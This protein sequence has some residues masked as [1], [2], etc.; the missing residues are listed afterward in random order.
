MSTQIAL[1]Y[2][3]AL[4]SVVP[5]D[6]RSLIVEE[7]NRAVSVL[8]DPKIKQVFSYPRTSKARKSELIR[9]MNLS[10]TMENF[11]LLLVEKSREVLLPLIEREFEH[12]VLKAQNTAI[13]EITSAITLS[14]SVLKRL[15]N[16][17]ESLTQK[18]IVLRNK[19][20]SKIGG[21]LIIKVDGQVVDGSITS[22]LKRLEQSLGLAE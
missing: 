16:Q 14:D 18:T 10:H 22:S 19:V 12:L 13:A 9:L 20:D 3:K 6:E 8:Q 17:L 4:F 5:S 1:R 15:Q 7:F 2:A 21:G 11:L